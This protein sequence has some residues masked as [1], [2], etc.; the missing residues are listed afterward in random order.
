MLTLLHH[1][2]Q[3]HISTDI[4]ITRLKFIEHS[5]LSH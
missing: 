2:I 3:H 5:L 4:R 1:K